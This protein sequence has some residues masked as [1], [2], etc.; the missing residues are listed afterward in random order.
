MRKAVSS[1]R[2]SRR[3]ALV[4]PTEHRQRTEV[5]LA[6]A[7]LEGHTWAI[8]ETWHRMAPMVL[9]MAQRCL[10]SRTEAED[11]TQEV[12]YRVFRKIDKL[13]DPAC[14]RSFIY[15]FAIR[16]LKSELRSRRV[17]AWLS[18]GLP[19]GSQ[20]PASTPDMEL[21]DLLARF[22][23][24]LDRLTPRDR[25]VF[26]LR[27]IEGMTVEEIANHLTISS[28]TVKRSLVYS[29]GMLSRW[30]IGDPHLRQLLATEMVPV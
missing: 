15:S 17:R 25:L 22:Y 27:R 30:V 8:G 9:A 1:G 7:L 16:V 23:R 18:F 10:G 20:Q 21:R 14:L 11:V 29:Q 4:T 2:T 24:L 12:F 6:M 3:L 26:T 5:E 19:E 13:Q 28:S